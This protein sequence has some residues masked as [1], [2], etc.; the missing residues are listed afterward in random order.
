MVLKLGLMLILVS[1]LCDIQSQVAE[2]AWHKCRPGFPLNTLHPGCRRTMPAHT[3]CLG[4]MK[5]KS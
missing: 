2:I 1:D 5:G 4:M 3:G